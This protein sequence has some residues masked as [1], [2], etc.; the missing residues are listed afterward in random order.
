[1]LVGVPCF[2]PAKH[3]VCIILKEVTWRLGLGG[4]MVI[5]ALIIFLIEKWRWH[6]VS[7]NVWLHSL[8]QIKCIEA[9]T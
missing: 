7:G 2:E 8:C 6:T 9:V 4:S 5:Y 1:M 3:E